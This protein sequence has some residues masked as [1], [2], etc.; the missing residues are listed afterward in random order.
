MTLA[1][2]EQLIEEIS[3]GG[4]VI[5][6]DDANRENEGDLVLAAESITPEQVNFLA[7]HARGLI[8]APLGPEI[9]ERLQLPSMHSKPSDPK[10]CAFTISVD[11]SQ[12]ISTGISAFDR[13]HT[14]RQLADPESTPEHLNRP[15]HIFPLKGK[16]GGILSRQGHTEASVHLMRRAG[17]QPAAVICE[18]MN[19][20]GSMARL[21][22]LEKFAELHGLLLGTID[23][24]VEE[25]RES[26]IPEA[27]GSSPV[28][29]VKLSSAQLPTPYGLFEIESWSV[30]CGEPITVLRQGQLATEE[31]ADAPLVRIHSAC[32]T[33]DVI[34]S[35]RCDCGSQLQMALDQI[36]SRE[37]GALLYLPQEGRGIGLTRKI[38]AYHLQQHE[39]LDT[40]EA[41]E[42]L[43]FPPDLRD[44]SDAAAIL[45]A[46]GG[47]RVRLMTNNPAK[48]EGLVT[49]GI[50]VV[51]RISIEP[52]PGPVNLDYLRAKKNKMGHLFEAI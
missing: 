45:R 37:W 13:A 36:G 29:P 9:V 30:D 22:D 39:G 12:G 17:L 6:I 28:K 40:V 49:N 4:M 3:R 31:G 51:E 2:V 1:T 33:G 42:R 52:D 19:E 24:L 23:S 48:V 47:T 32:F 26:Q 8:C 25:C 46:L 18:V 14:L 15:G 41:N 10:E 43:G 5:L 16:H 20:D 34:G 21:E 50:D 35:L 27:A 7:T 38:Q 44:Y 11:S